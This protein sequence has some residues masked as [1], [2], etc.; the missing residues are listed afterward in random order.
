MTIIALA[1]WF[2]V[3]LKTF[4]PHIVTSFI[5]MA[6][7]SVMMGQ[8]NSANALIRIYSRMIMCTFLVIV[9]VA[10][11]LFSDYAPALVTLCS[12]IFYTFLFRCYQD[13]SSPGWIFYAYLAIGLASV[14]WVQ[15]LF[16]LP[17]LW[18][19]TSTNLLAMNFRN[20]IASLLGVIAPYWFLLAWYAF[21]NDIPA[22]AVHFKELANFG[23]VAGMQVLT[24][25]Q[26]VTLAFTILLA[27]TG[28]IHFVNKAHL[29]NIR[30]RLLYETF[31]TID[32]LTIA[33]IILQP[34]HFK[35]L[36][37]I[38]AVNTSPLIGHFIALTH[39]KWTNRYFI[40]LIIMAMAICAYNIWIP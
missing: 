35:F 38:L 14:F 12:T 25:H 10:T 27:V 31:I 36:Y 7:A 8:L 9:S 11:F 33:F 32:L 1:I 24:S 17:F 3:G 29:D 34:Q 4:E 23:H 20:F 37:G 2:A 13:K 18:I 39:T 28:M 15:V 19:I 6:M 5:C 30:T 22:F 40:L 16:F 26:L 21:K